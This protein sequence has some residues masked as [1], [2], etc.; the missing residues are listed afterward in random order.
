M[1]RCNFSQPSMPALRG[2]S[3][4]EMLLVLAIIAGLSGLLVSGAFGLRR[5]TDIVRT[6]TIIETL[7]QAIELTA[8]ERG[9]PV[10]PAE[11]PLAGSF[12]SSS[13]PRMLFQR[14]QAQGGQL[15][16][17]PTAR[18]GQAI[19][20]VSLD[21]V[22][23][24]WQDAVL[25]PD[26]VYADPSLPTLYGLPRQRIGYLGA[27][28]Q[29]VQ[30]HH[31][32]PRPHSSSGSHSASEIEAMIHGKRYQVTSN[33]NESANAM[34]ID[35]V[36]GSTT[37]KTELSK[38]NSKSHLN[39]LDAL[40]VGAGDGSYA[41][42]GRVFVPRNEQANQW[43][44]GFVRDPTDNLWKRYRIRGL[45]I[46]D[47]WGREILYS[48]SPSGVIRLMSAGPDGVFARHPGNNG[49]FDGP[50]NQP[51]SGDDQDGWND[52]IF[53]VTDDV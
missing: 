5:S 17:S 16:N 31:L 37:A 29:G 41:V 21:Q 26:D 44:P 1:S 2:F 33:D 10:I 9:S 49:V 12:G 27:N 4:I 11:H 7:R 52:N 15:L 34:L 51:P 25:L 50:A 28:L 30:H 45:A 47:S 40:Y 46:Y 42:Y 35:Y 14:S 6:E 3:L 53:L 8:S 22:P 19:K 32:L 13:A 18:T 23:G 20:G 24:S 39:E 38:L 48:L 43:E 36:L